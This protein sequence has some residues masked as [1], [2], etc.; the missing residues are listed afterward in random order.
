[1][2]FVFHSFCHRP[3]DG[4]LKLKPLASLH[5]EG[6]CVGCDCTIDKSEIYFCMYIPMGMSKIKIRI[7]VIVRE[8]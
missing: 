8:K 1:M 3:D 4:F 6:V 2:E 5:V 7:V